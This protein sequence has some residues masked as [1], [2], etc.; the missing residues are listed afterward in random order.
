MAELDSDAVDPDVLAAFHKSIDT[1]KSLGASVSSVSLP[2]TQYAVPVYYII[3]TAEAS[4]NLARFDG[5]R[6]GRRADNPK[7]ILDM[8]KAYPRPIH[9][10][11]GEASHFAGHL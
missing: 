10:P 2:S 5:V 8:Y 11:R 7:D 3:A 4:S 1:L 6:Y 9:W